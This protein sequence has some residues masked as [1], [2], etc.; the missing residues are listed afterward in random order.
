MK[1]IYLGYLKRYSVWSLFFRKEPPGSLLTRKTSLP[2][3]IQELESGWHAL[4]V[5]GIC[6]GSWISL[7]RVRR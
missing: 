1:K 3:Q 6:E 4:Q 5:R 7:E 2:D